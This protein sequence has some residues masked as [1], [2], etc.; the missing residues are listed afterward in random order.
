MPP[1]VFTTP[2]VAATTSVAVPGPPL[3]GSVSLNAT[4]V[5]SPLAGVPGLFGLLM[6]KVTVVVPFKGMLAAPNDLAIVGGATTV[7]VALAVALVPPSLEVTCTLLFLSPAVVPVTFTVTAHKALEATVPPERLSELEPAVAVAV[8]LQVLFRF[9]VAA[10]TSPAGRVSVNDSPVRLTFV[11]GLL[12]L[13]VSDVVP[14]SG[15]LLAPKLLVTLAGE[16][17]IRVAVL[18]VAPVPPLVELIA[19]VVL[20]TVPDWVPV[21]F[22][23][24]VQVAPGVAIDPPVRLML[25]ELA[26]AVTVPPQELVTPGVD[27]TCRPFVSVSLKAIP[28]SALV[29]LAGLVIVKLTVVVPFRVM[30]A[31]PNALLIVG[32]ATTLIVAV[33]LARPVPP[34]VEVIAPVVLLASPTAVP[35]TFTVKVQ[36]APCATVPP[37]RLITPVPAVAVTVPL[38]VLTTPGV[39]ATTSVPVVFGSVSLKATPVRSPAAVV[40]GLLMVKVTVVVPFSGMLAA[41]KALLM[42]G[43]ATTVM[44]ALEVLPVP[45]SVEVT[46]TLLLFTP[47]VVPVTLTVTVQD[48]PAARMPPESVT[49][50]EPAAAVAVPLQVLLRFGVEATTRPAGRLSVKATPFSVTLVFGLVMLNVSEVVPFSGML[51]APNVLVILGGAATIRVAVLLVAPVPPLVELTAPVMLVT[52]PDCVPVTFTTIVQVDPGAAIDPP[53]KLIEVELAAAVTVPPQLLVTPG[54]EATCNPPVSVSLKAIPVSDVVFTAGFAMVNVTVVVPFSGMAAAPN[55]LLIVGGA[56]ILSVAVL[57]VAPVPPSVEV[58]APVV[59]AASPAAVPVTFTLSVQ[60]VFFATVPPERLITP[61]PAVAVTVPPQVL[62]TPGVAAT[63]SVPVVLGRVSLK[64]TPLRSTVVFGLLMLKVTVVV[65]FSGTL[66]A[67]NAL[68]IVGGATTVMDALEVLPVP[69]TVSETVTLLFFT[70]AVVP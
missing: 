39:A 48:A 53:V 55:A 54:V 70:P 33:L 23:T 52:V 12:M 6:V 36:D 32:G 9:G 45:P 49:E 28:V 57:L 58:M 1:Q 14:F 30:L 22:T 7:T 24:I 51:A 68:A 64:A 31:A 19:P 46:C 17:T 15:I 26:A 65:P 69:A 60:E 35:V 59:F 44:V 66:A 41:P 18:L 3:T 34:L 37:E 42:V 50:L 43:A 38:Q 27:A 20:V 61:V 4:P 16:A 63:T 21:T 2:G 8:P 40:F 29:L 62:T 11:F 56:T 47:A 10:I 13:M 67:P 5:R 25:V